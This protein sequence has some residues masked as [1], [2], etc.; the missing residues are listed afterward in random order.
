MNITAKQPINATIYVEN[1]YQGGSLSSDD[2]EMVESIPWISWMQHW[3]DS[4]S[5]PE[6]QVEDCELS[7]RLT[8]DRQIQELNCQYRAMDKPTDVL[9]FA[10]TEADIR[11]PLDFTEPIYLGDI[12]ISLE[13]AVK[14]ATERQHSIAVELAWLASHGLLHLLGWDHP[15][16]RSLKQMLQRQCELIQLLNLQEAKILPV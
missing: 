2:L 16:D 6:M 1:I 5:T 10:A 7:L 15:D 4:I 3:L 11:L 12:V 14:Q 9:A 13:T 8:G